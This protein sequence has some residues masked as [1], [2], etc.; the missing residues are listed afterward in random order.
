MGSL[1]RSCRKPISAA[2]GV[3]VCKAPPNSVTSKCRMLNRSS[4]HVFAAKRSPRKTSG[5]HQPNP[6][7]FQPRCSQEPTRS[8]A[9]DLQSGLQ[10][11][12]NT[13]PTVCVCSPPTYLFLAISHGVTPL[14]RQKEQELR[15]SQRTHWAACKHLH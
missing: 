4:S 11:P 9:V 3:R 10:L 7:V 2:L 14:R 15:C 13:R 6:L 1:I 8:G 12:Q 5:R